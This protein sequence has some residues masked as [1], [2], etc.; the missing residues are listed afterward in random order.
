MEHM[1]TKEVHN[2]VYKFKQ[3]IRSKTN[4]MNEV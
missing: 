1:E 4:T 2:Y 3:M